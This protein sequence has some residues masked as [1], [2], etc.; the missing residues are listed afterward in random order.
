[1]AASPAP[2]I[3]FIPPGKIRCIVT[4]KLR[5]DKPEEHVR[6]RVARSLIED[7]GYRRE[8]L[9]VEFG[10]RVGSRRCRVDIAIFPPNTAH[11]QEN[12]SIIVECKPE[13]KKPTDQADGVEQLKSYVSACLNCHFGMWFGS[14]FQ[15]WER[16][17]TP[18]GIA[19]LLNAT[20]IPRFGQD[21]PQPP[22]FADLVPAHE[23]LIAVFRRCHNYI[24]GNQGLQKEPAFQELLKIIFCKVHDEENLVG[25][26]KFFIGNDDRRSEIGQRRLRN[27]VNDLFAAVKQR[28]SYIFPDDVEIQPK[29]P[30]WHTLSG[31]CSA[32]L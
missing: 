12:V 29:T 5:S 2:I 27:V 25:D 23:E 3:S 15:V 13:D 32:S 31:S 1:M 19:E 28:Y 17:A 20:D 22:H 14:E 16:V 11:R 6:Q 8:D 4:G 26:L 7:Y 9:A 18:D 10:I 30:F 21:A 24:Y